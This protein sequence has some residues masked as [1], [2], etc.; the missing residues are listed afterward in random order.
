MSDRDQNSE[1]YNPYNSTF[2]QDYMGSTGGS[3]TFP[4]FGSSST[5]P[6]MYHQSAAY[7]H[8]PPYMS[9]TDCLQ[10]T[11]S[12]YN[13]LSGAFDMSCNSLSESACQ[14]DN[15]SSEIQN[16]CTRGAAAG[17]TT[18]TTSA[19][20]PNSSLSCSSNEAR[21]EEEESSKSNTEMRT[22][23]SEDGDDKSK[24]L[25]VLNYFFEFCLINCKI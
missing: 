3:S 11:A 21:G 14:V 7:D 20:N 2:Y 6:M 19:E 23:G 1:A 16:T 15:S 9:F 24:K 4:F 18:T 10:G 22:K 25:W 8:H 17:T 12:D 13:T 5:N